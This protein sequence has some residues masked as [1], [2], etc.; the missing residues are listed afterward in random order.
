MA[1]HPGTL[2]CRIPWTEEPGG[3]QCIGSHRTGQDWSD[4]AAAAARYAVCWWQ[5]SSKRGNIHDAREKGAARGPPLIFWIIRASPH[6]LLIHHKNIPWH[7]QGYL[8]FQTLGML[9]KRSFSPFL[10]VSQRPCNKLKKLCYFLK[11]KYDVAD[12]HTPS[13]FKIWRLI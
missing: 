8:A 9:G 10:H 2:A 13:N 1:T 5:S 12:L 7:S 4:Y 11:W 6:P 3:L